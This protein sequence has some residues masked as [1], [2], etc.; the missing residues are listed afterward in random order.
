MSPSALPRLRPNA[1]STYL[2]LITTLLAALLIMT[3]CG[4]SHTS[5][6]MNPTASNAAANVSQGGANSGSGH[7]GTV[8]LRPEVMITGD[9]VPELPAPAG[10]IYSYSVN[11]SNGSITEVGSNG[12]NGTGALAVNHANTLLYTRELGP[13]MA[14]YSIGSTGSL[15]FL[16]DTVQIGAHSFEGR[17]A[18][19]PN[20]QFLYCG[21]FSE[22]V[23]AYRLNQNGTMSEL[24][25]NPVPP[26][27][28]LAGVAPSGNWLYGVSTALAS[29]AIVV[30]YQVNSQTG[31][32]SADLS[33]V[34]RINTANH[35]FTFGDVQLD[36]QGKYLFVTDEANNAI[37]TFSINPQTGKV[38]QTATTSTGSEVPNRITITPSDSFLYV[39]SATNPDIL[40]FSISQN[41]ALSPTNGGRAFTL[42]PPNFG[43]IQGMN[44]DLSGH[45]LYAN[46]FFYIN[47]LAIDQNTGNLATVVAPQFD[48]GNELTDVTFANLP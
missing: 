36:P 30:A 29:G 17:I 5:S 3:A 41:G 28:Y 7:S 39:G 16:F 11:L 26:E 14:S 38:Q 42:A 24:P 25:R 35:Q 31:A 12:D 13:S 1:Q 47:G 15:N 43:G 20:D 32:I 48:S 37:Y 27:S 22:G 4:S 45:Y 33:N 8:D 23:I 6:M 46:T 19:H 10:Q 2:L 44:V 9:F 21:A 40:G 18:I 34:T